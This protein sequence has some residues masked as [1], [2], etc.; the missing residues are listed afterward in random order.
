[1]RYLSNKFFKIFCLFFFTEQISSNENKSLYKLNNAS[2]STTSLSSI[3]VKSHLDSFSSCHSSSRS[4][5]SHSS[6]SINNKIT[7]SKYI[8][9][10]S[11]EKTNYKLNNKTQLMIKKIGKFKLIRKTINS[12]FFFF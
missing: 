10:I 11:L 1:M 5:T 2:K 6:F 7:D 8:K 9:P 4:S 3:V 12:V